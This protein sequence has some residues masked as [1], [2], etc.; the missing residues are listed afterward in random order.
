MLTGSRILFCVHHVIPLMRWPKR[1][2]QRYTKKGGWSWNEK[3]KRR[4]IENEKRM[5][6]HPNERERKDRKSTWGREIGTKG[7]QN[8]EWKQKPE[9]LSRIRKNEE[10][11]DKLIKSSMGKE[12]MWK[13]PK[14]K[15]NHWRAGN[16]KRNKQEDK[17]IRIW[18]NRYK[19]VCIYKTIERRV[20]KGKNAKKNIRMRQMKRH[21]GHERM[22]DFRSKIR[23]VNVK[24]RTWFFIS[25]N[26][27][28]GK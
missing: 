1:N 7:G 26:I 10:P 24:K 17:R 19:Y 25:D 14:L 22:Q 4:R 28:N 27:Y 8:Q 21:T 5:A 15:Q 11:R 20:V 13:L 6:Y 3:G 12:A 2:I 16:S 9:Q 23:T 18:W